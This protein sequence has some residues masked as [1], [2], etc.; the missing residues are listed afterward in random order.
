M[1]HK[2]SGTGTVDQVAGLVACEGNRQ[3]NSGNPGNHLLEVLNLVMSLITVR[4]RG[5]GKGNVLK[6]TIRKIN[7]H[8]VIAA[9]NSNFEDDYALVADDHMHLSDVWVLD[10]GDLVV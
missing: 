10:S 6:R 2:A 8:L 1:C 4:K 7:P 3:G 9:E 5:T